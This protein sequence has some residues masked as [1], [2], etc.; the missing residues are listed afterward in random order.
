[1]L[2][3]PG[4]VQSRAESLIHGL[5]GR[6]PWIV[7][8]MNLLASATLTYKVHY[9]EGSFGDYYRFSKMAV[10]EVLFGGMEILALE[11]V[12]SP[13]RFVGAARKPPRSG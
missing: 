13:P 11:T 8:H 3:V 1:M 6:L 12:M 9:E 4:F 2:G 5:A 10:E 7:R